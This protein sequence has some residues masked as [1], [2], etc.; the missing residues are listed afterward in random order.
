[1]SNELF[2]HPTRLEEFCSFIV[3]LNNKDSSSSLQKT[4]ELLECHCRNVWSEFTTLTKSEANSSSLVMK[5]YSQV[6]QE[7]IIELVM[8]NKLNGSSSSEEDNM[9]LTTSSLLQSS[10]GDDMKSTIH[11]ILK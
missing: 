5:C 6:L 4:L 2:Q 1:M 10:T 9:F 7:G 8:N 11:F 3:N